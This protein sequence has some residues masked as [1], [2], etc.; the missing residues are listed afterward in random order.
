MKDSDALKAGGMQPQDNTL[1]LT[2]SPSENAHSHDEKRA[3]PVSSRE[4]GKIELKE[5]D[6]YDHLGFSFPTWKKWLILTVIFWVQISMNFN[7]S[8]Y[9]N[10]VEP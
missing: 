9:S 8:I 1:D 7:T 10:A 4:D 5:E 6:N 3:E 2:S